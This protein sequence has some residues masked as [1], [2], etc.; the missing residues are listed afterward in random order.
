ME[1]APVL[2]E[3]QINLTEKSNPPVEL[4]KA[5][6]ELKDVCEKFESVFLSYVLSQMRKSGEGEK[7][8]LNEDS[9]A[10][11]IYKGMLDEKYALQMA[12]SG[13]IGIAQMLFEQLQGA[14]SENGGSSMPQAANVENLNAD[15]AEQIVMT[16]PE[17]TNNLTGKLTNQHFQSLRLS[18]GNQ[19]PVLNGQPSVSLPAPT[20]LK[21]GAKSAGVGQNQAISNSQPISA[22]QNRIM[23]QIVQKLGNSLQ[24]GMREAIINLEPPDLGHLHIRLMLDSNNILSARINVDNGSVANA[25]NNNMSTFRSSLLD[26]HGIQIDSFNIVVGNNLAQLNQ[27][28]GNSG[29][30]HQENFTGNSISNVPET[31]LSESTE[32]IIPTRARYFVNYLV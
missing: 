21:Y 6:K 8:L 32:E 12:K 10:M 15:M 29:Q 24:P 11:K 31:G 7:S 25:L 3:N 16:L 1:V 5:E 23:I 28:N 9:T 30:Y 14:L 17:N 22:S 26:N 18:N 2:N 13:Q 20:A 4:S 19:S 27:G